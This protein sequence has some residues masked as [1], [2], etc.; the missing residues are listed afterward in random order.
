M[1]PAPAT[2]TP[3]SRRVVQ[4]AA[5]VR[6][7]RPEYRYVGGGRFLPANSAARAECA[8]FNR[9]VDEVNARTAKGDR[10]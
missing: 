3:R 7:D 1:T 8:A 2:T 5:T 4:L 6:P 10:L 9:W